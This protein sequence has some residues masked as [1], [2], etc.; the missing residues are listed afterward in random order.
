[1]NKLTF[2]LFFL[3]YG[4]CLL[5]QN[6]ARSGKDY[7]MFFYVTAFQPGWE[8]LPGT[9]TDARA[10]GKEL[11][12]SYGFQVEYVANPTKTEIENK[13]LELNRRSYGPKDQL[14]L[15]FSM[16][17]H[18][19]QAA[20]R[21]Y[22]IP[23]DGKTPPNDP[24]GR[25]WL[26]Y[27]DL[28]TFLSQNT[29][30]HILLSL[31]ACYSGAFG[32][33]WMSYPGSVEAGADAECRQKEEYAL[34]NNCYLYFTSGSREVRT[35]AQSK[36]ANRWLNA[37]Q[38][39]RQK[40][41][42]TTNELRYYFGTIENP[43]PEGGAFSKKERNSGDFIFIHKTACGA[44][45]LIDKTAD[46]NA[47]LAAKNADDLNAYKKYCADFPN[48]D[49]RPLANQR[50]GELEAV[51]QE[52]LAWEKAKL[53]NT[54]TDY[55]NFIRDHPRSPYREVAEYHLS[56]LETTT[57]QNPTAIDL[58]DMVL[59]QG[60][61]FRMGSEE[62]D[63][64]SDEKPV[65]KVELSD[66]YLHRYEV[67]VQEF[68]QFIAA[69]GYQTD[70]DKDGGSYAWD[71]S[72]WK[73]KAGVNWK[74]GADGK[75]RPAAEQNH[76]VIHVSWND[77]VAYCNWLSGQHGLTKVYTIT[78]NKVTANWDAN[79]YR[80]PTE[81]EWEY[82]ARSRGQDYKYAWGNGGP[83]GNIADETTK[84]TFSDWTIWQ[85]YTDG[86]LYTAPVNQFEQ[87]DL[88]LFNMSGNVWEWCWDWYN[89]DY[90]GKSPSRDPRGPESGS[91]RVL[92][93]GSWDF[94][95]AVLRC[96]DRYGSTPDLRNRSC[97]FRLA[98][99]AR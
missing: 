29:C 39:G 8:P 38:D 74:C 76:P 6:P 63:A 45:P 24:F 31:D 58:P 79:G 14:L 61:S 69:T 78:G 73:K 92:R 62:G 35:P 49:F 71:G 87:G 28:S 25:S 43:K 20:D 37:L 34:Y 44:A 23:A 15:F 12:D 48:G 57:T 94:I 98:R 4:A 7:A 91:Y 41:V 10:I 22:L 65:H 85:G 26:S 27:D 72:A 47:W 53:A 51:Q 80:L 88:G 86:Y 77:A 66:F 36:F 97:G 90:Y 82:A 16:H 54:P 55:R 50:I 1:M 96:A 17:G 81:A 64:E 13:I 93:G 2:L 84:K 68:G 3:L 56:Q 95:P 32:D 60:G 59:V 19:I 11:S 99:A 67:T 52:Q 30:K 46:R 42:L 75:V 5:A 83:K 33:R 70:A 18:F 89:D 40:R 9:E 21:G